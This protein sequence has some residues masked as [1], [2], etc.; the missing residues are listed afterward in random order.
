M[1]DKGEVWETNDGSGSCGV[2]HFTL[3]GL[4]AHGSPLAPGHFT[5]EIGRHGPA[6]FTQ[7]SRAQYDSAADTLYLTGYSAEANGSPYGLVPG[8][9]YGAPAYAVKN[10]GTV[11][12]RYDHWS[13]GGRKYA[14]A[15]RLPYGGVHHDYEHADPAAF[16]VC[17]DYVFVG[18]EYLFD[19]AHSGIIQVYRASDGGYAGSLH[20]GPEVGSIEGAMDIPYGVRAFK[21]AGGEYLVFSEDDYHAKVLMYRRRPKNK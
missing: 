10:V 20:A 16:C 13:Q 11:I 3:Q 14:W 4:D 9:G 2:R 6:P 12:A 17:G 8:R 21:R 15:I 19:D 5:Q 7:L 18:Y 1:D